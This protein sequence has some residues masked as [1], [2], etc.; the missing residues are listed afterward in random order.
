MKLGIVLGVIIGAVVLGA[1]MFAI[2][3]LAVLPV[4]REISEGRAD[5]T[6]TPVSNPPITSTVPTLSPFTPITPSPGQTVTPNS[7]ISFSLNV[8]KSELSGLNS[9]LVTAELTNTGTGDAHNTKA[10]LEVATQGTRIKVNGQDSLIIDLGS[11]KAG[12]MVTR[13]VSLSFGLFDG[14]KISQSGATLTLNIH[15]DET[16]QSL[17]YEYKP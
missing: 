4:T 9:A 7:S 11:I 14:L 16:T 8:P 2:V 5:S 10:F 15:S 6:Q 1:A 12:Q 17:T 3:V 13:D